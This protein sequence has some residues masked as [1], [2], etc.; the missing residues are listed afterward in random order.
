MNKTLLIV[1]AV[2]AV[3]IT[4]ALTG[5][6]G[7]VTKNEEVNSKWSQIE[8]QLQRR[9]DLIPNLVNTVQGY[10][11][12]ERQTIQAVADARAKLA[13]AQGPNA[14]AQAN[15]EFNSALSRLLVVAENYPNL[16]ADQNFRVLMDELAG[17]ENRLSVARK[18][19]NE[20]VQRY[21]T[22]IRSLPSS[23]FAGPLGFGSKEYFKADDGAKQ[24]PQVKL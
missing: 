12:H 14:K 24:A 9:G 11:S 7:L 5:Y 22:A 18:D 1:L 16:K 2:A 4:G 15:G 21:N 19:Y 10:A 17:T 23:L 8:N 3:L 20:S 6:N 13:N